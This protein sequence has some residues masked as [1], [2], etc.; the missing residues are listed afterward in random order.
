MNAQARIDDLSE[1]VRDIQRVLLDSGASPE[2]IERATRAMRAER[3]ALAAEVDAYTSAAKCLPAAFPLSA[4]GAFLVGARVG[5]QDTWE[6]FGAHLG[7]RGEQARR[8][9]HGKFISLPLGRVVALLASLP[10][11]VSVSVTWETAKGPTAEPA[12]PSE[13]SEPSAEESPDGADG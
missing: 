11:R 3:D 9:A 13:P 6:E 2:T 1:K 10:V 5:T 8:Y 12:E 7:V 4:L